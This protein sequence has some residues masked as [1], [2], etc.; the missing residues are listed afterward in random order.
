M[1]QLRDIKIFFVRNRRPPQEDLLPD[2]RPNILDRTHTIGHLRQSG[3]L[4]IL[5][6]LLRL[7]VGSAFIFGQGKGRYRIQHALFLGGFLCYLMAW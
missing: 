7:F 3:M 1:W 6:S 5:L 2:T 4:G